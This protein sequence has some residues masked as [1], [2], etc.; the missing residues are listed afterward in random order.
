MFI[1]YLCP[2]CLFFICFLYFLYLFPI[3][4]LFFI[5]SV[6]NF[7]NISIKDLTF[8]YSCRLETYKLILLNSLSKGLFIWGESSHLVETSHLKWGNF[9]PA[10]SWE[11]YPTWMRYFSSRLACMPIFKQLCYFHC[12]LVSISVY[13]FI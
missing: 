3:S 8:Y 2:L 10:F 11:I 5:N 13:L 7:R 4:S 6:Q 9:Y 12:L 1:F